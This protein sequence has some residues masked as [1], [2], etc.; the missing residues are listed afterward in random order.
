MLYV[1]C[2]IK[3]YINNFNVDK[4]MVGLGESSLKSFVINRVWEVD[5]C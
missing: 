1:I 3:V 5:V 2:N 4:G